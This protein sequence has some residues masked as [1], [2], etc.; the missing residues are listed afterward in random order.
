M[1]EFSFYSIY[2]L[3]TSGV[4]VLG[5]IHKEIDMFTICYFTTNGA[6]TLDY[7]FGTMAMA[8]RLCNIYLART[9]IHH[10]VVIP[11]QGA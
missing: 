9:G 10:Y 8:Q 3:L 4:C 11:T 1:F 5:I 6:V 2:P 7:E